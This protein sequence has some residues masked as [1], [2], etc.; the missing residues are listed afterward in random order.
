MSRRP[1]QDA[2]RYQAGNSH[3][4]IAEEQFFL[5]RSR[6]SEKERQEYAGKGA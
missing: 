4:K 5:G 2:S 1:V 3:L 6:R